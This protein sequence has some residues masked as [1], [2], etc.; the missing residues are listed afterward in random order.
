MRLPAKGIQFTD[1]DH[2]RHGNSNGVKLGTVVQARYQLS[3][4]AA[5]Y[6]W[7]DQL[8]IDQSNKEEKSHQVQLMGNIYSCASSV[9]AWLGLASEDS[10][11][12]RIFIE[13]QTSGTMSKSDVDLQSTSS[14]TWK[15]APKILQR[16]YWT[17][18]WI[19]QELALAKD[20]TFVCGEWVWPRSDL[21]L[22]ANLGAAR[23]W[24]MSCYGTIALAKSIHTLPQV[25]LN[26]YCPTGDRNQGFLLCEN[27]LDKIYGIL[28]MVVPAQ[29]VIVDYNKTPNEVLLDVI[30]LTI[31]ILAAD[32]SS[33]QWASGEG[34]EAFKISLDVA[35]ASSFALGVCDTTW[36]TK[37][38]LYYIWEKHMNRKRR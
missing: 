26:F 13:Q 20:V 33:A 30:N 5:S 38:A 23:S 21:R 10:Q 9:V 3:D 32:I 17:R 2:N 1:I 8:T 16:P 25:I 6:L 24:V 35:R 36:S 28:G 37:A 14:E 19:M 34:G 18:L 12:A 15:L 11:H 31:E 27:K 4:I 7:I 22:L 29:R